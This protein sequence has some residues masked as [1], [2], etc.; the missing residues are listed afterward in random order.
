VRP[1]VVLGEI[2]AAFV[3]CVLIASCSNT[4]RRSHSGSGRVFQLTSAPIRRTC[5]GLSVRRY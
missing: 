1:R 5:A 2:A 3:L 4:V